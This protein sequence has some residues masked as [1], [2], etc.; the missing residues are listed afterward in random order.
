MR[1]S[2]EQIRAM[3]DAILDGVIVSNMMGQ[4]TDTNEASIAL[5]G[6]ESREDFIGRNILELLAMNDRATASEGWVMAL[7]AGSCGSRS[8]TFVQRN[9][10]LVVGELT[11]A[12][13]RDIEGNPI[14]S[15]NV[16]R[17]LS[18]ERRQACVL[19]E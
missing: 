10:G 18:T 19:D 16:A 4:I 6:Y 11:A 14:G 12:L 5:L 8:V 2:A 7:D 9:G 3:F 17:P 13:L 15:V 1:D